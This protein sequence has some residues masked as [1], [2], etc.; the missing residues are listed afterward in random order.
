MTEENQGKESVIQEFHERIP[1]RWPLLGL[2]TVMAI[3][4][5]G[6]VVFGV[7]ALYRHDHPPIKPVTLNTKE[8]AKTPAV[9]SASRPNGSSTASTSSSNT[10][11]PNSGP[12]SV[13]SLFVGS[14]LA[15][16]GLHYLINLRR[17]VKK[18]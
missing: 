16:S 18:T 11:L 13:V 6:L 1:G 12:G 2:H 7:R 3:I 17:D 9:D 4:V 5:A 14:V 8:S 10:N 15:A